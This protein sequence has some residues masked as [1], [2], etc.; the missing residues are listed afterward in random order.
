[1]SAIWEFKI[2]AVFLEIL[3]GTKHKFKIYPLTYIY[4]NFDGFVLKMHYTL[5]L[6]AVLIEIY[7]IQI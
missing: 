7:S 2:A 6:A 4:A 5:T 1:M 3:M